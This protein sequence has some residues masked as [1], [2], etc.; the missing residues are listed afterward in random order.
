MPFDPLVDNILISYKNPFSLLDGTIKPYL[1]PLSS[2][3]EEQKMEL[4]MLRTY[5]SLNKNKEYLLFD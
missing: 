1:F 2:I 3:T 5:V 4:N